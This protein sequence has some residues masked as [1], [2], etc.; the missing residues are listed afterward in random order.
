LVILF[1]SCV[2]HPGGASNGFVAGNSSGTQHNLLGRQT[3][4]VIIY[5][6]FKLEA[7]FDDYIRSLWSQFVYLCAREGDRLTLAA[8]EPS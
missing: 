2:W 8:I 1:F 5:K 4:L 7:H 6:T 3:F